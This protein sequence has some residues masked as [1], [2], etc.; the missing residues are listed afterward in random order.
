MARSNSYSFTFTLNTLITTAFQLVNI[1]QTEDTVSAADMATAKT[2]LNSMIKDWESDGV[3]MWKRR[4]GILFPAKSTNNYTLG[5]TG[6][7]VCNTFV[8]TTLTSAAAASATTLS[9]ASTG[10]TI[11]DYIG[12]EL[13]NGTRQWTT[14]ATIPGA[15]SVTIS[16]ALTSAAASGLTVV[17]YTSKINRPLKITRATTYHLTTAAETQIQDISEDEYFDLPIKSTAGRPNNFYYDKLLDNGVIYVFP[18]PNN[19]KEVIKFTYYDS[20]MD[21]VSSSD[22][23]D[24]PQEWFHTILYNLACELCYAW[25]KFVELDKYEMK[26]NAL[27]TKAKQWDGDEASLKIKINN[28]G[29]K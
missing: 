10:M 22:N 6:T 1:Y 16:V 15:T 25:Q 29:R 13:T 17:S 18:T 28:N 27:K 5:A 4:Q 11:G 14:I 3:R 19:V 8:S 20:I 24:F 23:F 7:N 2:L 12:I 21:M 9:L 26:A